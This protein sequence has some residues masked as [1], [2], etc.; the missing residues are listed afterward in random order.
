MIRKQAPLFLLFVCL[1]TSADVD[2]SLFSALKWRNIGPNR[3]GRSLACAGS[4][5]RPLEYYFAAVGGGLWKTVDGG[6]RWE[7]VTDGQLGSSS[8]GAIA[9]SESNP[10]IVY[11][12]MGETE[13][14]G[15]IMQGDGVYKSTDAGKTW[16]KVGLA[17]TQAIARIRTD[18]KNPD[19]VYVA[20][21]GHP[22]GPNP[23]R[24]IFRSADGG[25]TWKKIL[26]RDDH[27]G[28]IDLAIDP[29]NSKV[30]FAS[31]WDVYRTPW[32]LNDGGPGSGLF[33]STDGGDHWS[34]ITRN[35]GMPKGIIGKICVSISGADSNRIYAMVEANDGG[36]F[37][38]NNAGSS[39]SL[40]SQD[41]RALQ[42]AFYFSRIYADPKEKDT[43]YALNVAFLKSSNGGKEFK[44]IRDQHGDHHDLWIDPTNNHRMIGSNDGGGTVSV[45]GGETWTSLD[46][47]TAQLYHVAITKDV[48]YQ[49]CGAQQDNTTVCVQSETGNGRRSG[50]GMFAPLYA[51]GG[52]ESGYVTPDPKDPNVFYGGSQGA[53]ITRFDRRSGAIRAIQAYPLFF[54]GMPASALKE[55][56]QWTF[57]IVFSPSDPSVLYTSSQ[58]LWK[59]TNQGQSW[60]RISPD[61]TRADPKTLGDSGGP[62]TK[63]QNGPEIYGTIFTIAPSLQD[64]A[65]IWTGSDDGLAYITR[66]GCKNWS[67]ITPQGLPEFSRISMIDASPSTAGTAYLAA[68]RYQLD[69]RK[70]YIYRTHDFGKT[71]TKIVNGLPQD[72]YVHVVREDPKRPGLLYAGTEHGL[73]VSF[74]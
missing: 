34:E 47:P 30:M 17:D 37:V 62:I 4:P 3:G 57:P 52:G 68:K 14:R 28:G 12:G 63:D 51:V 49:A 72:D 41:R 66:D 31:L 43:I 16:R 20:A 7:P 13:L 24:G 6:I 67:N 58:H 54:S 11:I 27:S 64:G 35:E 23:E 39:W 53:L 60:E 61:L 71:W 50:W 18:P 38:S 40:V 55:R 9:V 48:P 1:A 46:F 8:V 36:L 10:D 59:T 70:P 15:N 74:R 25:K 45:N 2:P 73:Y 69:D 56:W 22:Y 32:L 65:T 29:H 26:Y 42:R 44:V 19:L 33:K 5:S 21:L